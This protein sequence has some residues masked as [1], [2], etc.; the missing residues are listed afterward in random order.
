MAVTFLCICTKWLYWRYKKPKFP[1]QPY[2]QI[3]DVCRKN[4]LEESMLMNL[5]KKTW[6]QGLTLRCFG[7]LFYRESL[8]LDSYFYSFFP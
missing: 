5:Q 8:V 6:T 4:D 1:A 2:T 7:R 3:N